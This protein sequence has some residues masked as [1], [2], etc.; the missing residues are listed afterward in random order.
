MGSG[1]DGRSA[2]TS[3]PHHASGAVGDV[4][5]GA[6]VITPVY[7]R[8]HVHMLVGGEYRVERRN[9]RTNERTLASS[10]AAQQEIEKSTSQPTEIDRARAPQDWG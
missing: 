10:H 3:A 6:A 2:A 8:L 4:G 9:E 5:R 1:V 7:W